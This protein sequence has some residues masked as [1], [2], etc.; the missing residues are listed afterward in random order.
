MEWCVL[1]ELVVILGR[2]GW[3]VMYGSGLIMVILVL[4][5]CRCFLSFYVV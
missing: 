1:I 2:N 5:L 3:Y 4:F